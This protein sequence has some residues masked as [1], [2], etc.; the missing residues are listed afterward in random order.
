[1]K[2][3]LRNDISNTMGIINDIGNMRNNTSNAAC[4][5]RLQPKVY[6]MAAMTSEL[7][8]Y[9]KRNLQ[10]QQG[11]RAGNFRSEGFR[12]KQTQGKKWRVLQVH[13]F[14]ACE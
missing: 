7:R 3:T 14:W 4:Q 12:L 13:G 1:M 5:V 10:R 8:V 2:N 11:A 9:G 6:R